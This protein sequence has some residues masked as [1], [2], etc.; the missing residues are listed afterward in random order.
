MARRK[1][2][3]V[4]QL[5][6]PKRVHR[7]LFGV[8]YEEDIYEMF[9]QRVPLLMRAFWWRI[10]ADI[11]RKALI[12]IHV[13][14]AAGTSIAH[15][16]YGPRNTLHISMRYYLA[17][18]PGFARRV[19]SFAVLRDPFDRFLSGYAYVR[20]KG[21]KESELADVF[22]ED[23]A[24]INS[25][26]DYLDYLEARDVFSLDFVMRPQSW[27]VVDL[28]TG[29]SLVKHLFVLGRDDEKLTRFLRGHGV[30]DLPRL[31]PSARDAALELT[32]EQLARVRRL[33]AGDFALIESLIQ[34][35]GAGSAT[36]GGTPY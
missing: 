30:A 19:E 13:P 28:K 24:G 3:L 4:P 11:R 29:E 25:I 22:I 27:F 9:C 35:P 16:L 18:A 31:N 34:S 23:T 7:A 12:F 5:A 26:D 15:S 36:P 33:Y 21:T 1:K 17:V 14:R 2:P 6:D 10:D 32:P 8:Y 20:N